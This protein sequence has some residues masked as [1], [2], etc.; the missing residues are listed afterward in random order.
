M[1]RTLALTLAGA[2]C[3]AGCAGW[4][5]SSAPAAQAASTVNIDLL[6]INDFHGRLAK[7]G[8]IAGAAVLAGAVNSFTASNPNTRLIS[9]GDNIGAS[10]FTSFIQQDKPTIDA[11]NSMKLTASALGNHEFDHGRADVDG[12]VRAAA[13]FPYLASNLYDSATGRPAYDQYSVSVVD[14]VRIGFIGAVTETLPS[15]VAVDALP[16]LEVRSIVPEVN[17]V[18][19]RLSDGDTT[20]GEAD[21]IV[22]LV[23]EGAATANIASS[24]DSST[25]G[26][27]VSEADGNIDAIVSGHTHQ[28]YAH[29]VPVAGWPA[30]LQRPIV[31]AGEYGETIGHLSLAV[32]SVT[33][34]PHSLSAELVPLTN[35]DTSPRYAPDAAVA[36]IVAAAEAVAAVRGA[37]SV[38]SISADL[39]KARQ[40]DGSDNRG[41]E[42]TL[43][44][45]VADAQLD[46]T[47]GVGAQIAFMNPGG[48]RVN[49]GYASSGPGD[50]DGNVTYREANNVQ[51]FA[52]TLIA[53]DLTGAQVARVLEQQWQ[54]TGTGRPFLKLGVSRGFEYSYDPSAPAGSRISRMTLDGLPLNS[55]ATYR[56]VA[57]KY[58]ADGGDN[59]STFAA[60]TNR[61]DTGRI[62]LDSMVEYLKHNPAAGPDLAQRA[63]GAHFSPGVAGGLTPGDSFT[64][65]L[66]SLLF[67][68][69][70]KAATTVEL[71]YRGAVIG[72]A[73]IDPTIVDTT[74]EVGRATITA[75]LPGDGDAGPGALTVTVPGTGTAIDLPI[76]VK[77]T[78]VLPVGG[79]TD[80]NRSAFADV[81]VTPS[82]APAGSLVQVNVP[83][84]DGRPVTVVGYA[85]QLTLTTAAAVAGGRVTVRIPAGYAP[86][87]HPLAVYAGD[88]SL[89]GW[90][91]VTVTPRARI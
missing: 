68:G 60:G 80:G 65:A 11:L 5:A 88:G 58:L 36:G 41:G 7:D 29:S 50:P 28:S 20:N 69:G 15:L 74:D 61:A 24:T 81:S 63:V 45:L 90:T 54:P 22:L 56:V 49:L 3:L 77:P 73:S 84:H 59:F 12:R 27:I 82:P 13:A 31:Q 42:S 16:G 4:E 53:L 39:N 8:I 10:T 25:F 67:S 32:D 83:G 34:Q 35:P 78:A 6:S 64:V 91:T 23:H 1:K 85:P 43:G 86:G 51:P 26:R 47:R 76:T 72:H 37:V 52:S 71:S 40:N 17:A 87:A 89:L 38:G 62:D 48:L 14:G 46:S 66:S 18:A 57:N 21:V 55:A 19:D 9:A 30:G 2:L 44:N 75:T 79:L 70:E 33:H